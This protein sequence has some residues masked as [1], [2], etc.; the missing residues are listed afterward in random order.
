MKMIIINIGDRMPRSWKWRAFA[1]HHNGRWTEARDLILD[2]LAQNPG[3][4][5]AKEIYT[6]LYTRNPQ[7][8]LAT[9][10]RTLEFLSQMGLL[11]RLMAADGQTRYEF[12]PP[13]PGAHHHHLICTRCGRIF[14]TTDFV[15]EEVELIRK[16]EK[17]IKEKHRFL[18]KD[19]QMTF[20][21]LCPHCQAPK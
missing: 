16:M 12:H 6:S 21:G 20:Y 13:S 5:S 9:V 7:L 10:Y 17:A 3:H 14:D 8:G 1:G 19:H 18:V 4:L 11:G 15:A 2:F